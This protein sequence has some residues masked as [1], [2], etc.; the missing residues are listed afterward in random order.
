VL[1]IDHDHEC[2]VTI[3]PLEHTDQHRHGV[4]EATDG[5]AR[6]WAALPGRIENLE[7]EPSV[8]RLSGEA[9]AREIESAIN[10]ALADLQGR[11]VWPRPA[12]RRPSPPTYWSC[13][14][15]QVGCRA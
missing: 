2:M 7:L 4:L 15:R 13:R 5:R 6:V 10:A 8:L 1:V 9:L 14:T 12:Q 3:R 11:G